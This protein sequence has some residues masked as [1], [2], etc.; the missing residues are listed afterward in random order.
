MMHACAPSSP[1]APRRLRA[2]GSMPLLLVAALLAGCGAKE[3]PATA[4]VMV[5]RAADLPTDPA[6]PAWSRAAL[7]RVPLILQ[8][9]VEP[10]LLQPSTPEVRVRAL[11]DGAR[12]AFHVAWTDSTEDALPGPASFSD[13]CAVQFPAVAG[14]DLPAPQMG[15]PARPVEIVFWSA[16]LQSVKDGRDPADIHALHP[17]E[18]VD[19]YPFNAASLEPGSPEQLAMAKR[20]APARAVG[21]LVSGDGERAVQD[22]VAAGPGTL[23]LAETAMSEGMGRRTANGWE[24]VIVR[25]LPVG[26][27]DSGRTHAAFAV[28]EGARD[29]VGARKMRSVWTA[30]AMSEAHP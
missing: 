27:Q 20:Y 28:W 15:E 19:P 29:E 3:E 1:F 18:A 24:I 6:D 16:V 25:P 11:T 4:E 26:L 14:P 10:R 22:L 8:D 2:A 13:A 5:A 12:V 30:V 23:T 17:N 9:M 21:N 7:C